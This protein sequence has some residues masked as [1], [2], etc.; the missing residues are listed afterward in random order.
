MHACDTIVVPS[1]YA[2]AM[3]MIASGALACVL[4]VAGL[5]APAAAWDAV[6]HR[7]ITWL[8]LDGLPA[9][10]PAF[11]KQPGVRD[12][13]AWQSAE[14]DRWRGVASPIL[15]HENAPDHFMDIEDLDAFGLTLETVSPLRMRF[16]RDM[17]VARHI[18]PA[19]PDESHKPYNER[20]DPAGDQEWPG[21]VMHAIAEHHAKLI[22]HFKTWRVL[23]AIND[24][25]RAEQVRQTEANITFTM[26]VL[27]H[28][29][30]DT[31]QPLH[32]TKHFNGWVGDNPHGYTEA[33][34][35][36]AYIDGGVL[37]RHGLDYHTLKPTQTY[38]ATVDGNSP[39]PATIAYIRR[40]N[41]QVEPLYK[42]EKDG[43]LD[44]E[45]G[46]IFITRQ[47]NEGANMLAA[48]Y[49][50]AWA[51]S[52][53]T[54]KD[55]DDFQKFD[56]F[57]AAQRPAADDA[58]RTTLLTPATTIG[59]LKSGESR[60]ALLIGEI[61]A[62]DGASENP[63][64]RAFVLK[65]ADR[66]LFIPSFNGHRSLQEGLGQRVIAQGRVYE[67]SSRDGTKRWAMSIED[68]KLAAP[69]AAT[70]PADAGR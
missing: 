3:K 52:T 39:W 43:E 57:S 49:A 55:I 46:R 51:A 11:L 19:G 35:F 53:I 22:S 27:S 67:H 70:T 47:L 28:F 15:R 14:P 10:A 8:A 1:W 20:L 5:S 54:Q 40:S 37:F 18:H 26:G 48:Y 58:E 17:S 44:R 7:A 61:K 36:H 63:Q 42:L 25:A 68:W 45:P 23:A 56:A 21:F 24:P 66:E 60:R 31:A 64:R 59:E 34:T 33:K 50:S 12:G 16:V 6:G 41:E 69:P 62:A 32:T 29:V 38:S 13:I 4:A 65:L 2:L 30:G 9:D